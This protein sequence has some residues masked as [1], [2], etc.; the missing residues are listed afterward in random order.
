MEQENKPVAS[1]AMQ[2]LG[3]IS[4]TSVFFL[5]AGFAYPNVWI[6]GM[7]PSATQGKTKGDL[8]KNKKK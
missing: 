5:T 7:D 2:V 1:A 4:R 6:E 8:Y 3:R